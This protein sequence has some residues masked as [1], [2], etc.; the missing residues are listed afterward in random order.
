MKQIFEKNKSSRAESKSRT[1]FLRRIAPGLTNVKRLKTQ[2]CAMFS[3]RFIAD[4][5]IMQYD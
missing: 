3:S 4:Q 5:S 2:I 1:Q